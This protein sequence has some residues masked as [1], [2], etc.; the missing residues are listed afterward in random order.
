M[1]AFGGDYSGYVFGKGT[2]SGDSKSK[3]YRKPGYKP[4]YEDLERSDEKWVSYYTPRKHVEEEPED[5]HFN[6]Y[7][8]LSSKG[9]HRPPARSG[10]QEKSR[11]AVGF[12]RAK[13][14]V[15]DS[16]YDDFYDDYYRG[17]VVE[18]KPYGGG[19]VNTRGERSRDHYGRVDARSKRN[20]GLNAHAPEIRKKTFIMG[21]AVSSGLALIGIIFYLIFFSIQSPIEAGTAFGV[22]DEASTYSVIK[23]AVDAQFAGK[24]ILLSIDGDEASIKLSDFELGLAMPNQPE[25]RTADGTDVKGKTETHMIRKKG[26][27]SY[28]ET[29]LRETLDLMSVQR[30][31]RAM[32]EPDY[33]VKEDKLTV[34]AGSDGYGIDYNI[35]VEKMEKALRDG[36]PIE[37]KMETTPA[38]SV[39]PDQIYTEVHA[40][41]QNA[42]PITDDQGNPGFLPDVVGVDLDKEAMRSAIA[43]GGTSWVIP[44]TLTQPETTLKELKASTCPDLLSEFITPYDATNT[45]RTQNIKL[46]VKKISGTVLEPGE[47]FSYNLALGERT[48]ENGWSKATV[49]TAETGTTE[50]YGGGICQV[51]STLYYAFVK[52]NLAIKERHNHMYT[53]PYIKGADGKVVLGR[54]ATVNWGNGPNATDGSFLDLKLINDKEYPI[55]I[56]FDTRPTGNGKAELICQIWG[57]ADGYTAEFV[58]YELEWYYP[59]TIELPKSQWPSKKNTTGQMG[60]KI[61]SYRKVYYNG[62]FVRKEER[63]IIS[64]YQALDNYRY[65]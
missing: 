24:I 5:R 22:M 41:M 39:D 26:N 53:V 35:V 56:T 11:S 1:A 58:N 2:G 50:D 32:S 16:Y 63:G 27:I 54:D 15:E 20:R 40:K 48:Q 43:A 6:P 51:S 52:A 29:L 17:D 31:G 38:P 13:P 7:D 21:S 42:K 3:A 10:E 47:E 25:K 65:V 12:S 33:W 55:K 4:Y 46:A 59:K 44:L 28:N 8:D 23:P 30:G 18:D 49:Y 36:K 57:T 45:G 62:E 19:R 14:Q 61:K 34:V 64:T 9:W 60:F 37:V